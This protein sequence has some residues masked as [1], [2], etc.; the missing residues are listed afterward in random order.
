[1][2]KLL[3]FKNEFTVETLVEEMIK[4]FKTKENGSLFTK[5]DVHDWA[6]KQRI[7]KI[8]GGDYI[9]VLKAGPLKILQL[10]KNPHNNYKVEKVKI[11]KIEK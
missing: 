10:S 9:K 1:M 2:A 8:Y 3:L 4:K 5:A 7:P 6:N 11:E